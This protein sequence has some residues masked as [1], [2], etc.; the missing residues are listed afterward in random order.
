MLSLSQARWPSAAQLSQ[1]CALM[2]ACWLPDWADLATRCLPMRRA[3]APSTASGKTQLLSCKRSEFSGRGWIAPLSGC[4]RSSSCRCE[5]D[6]RVES[7][8]LADI[9]EFQANHGASRVEYKNASCLV[10]MS[11]RRN[12]RQV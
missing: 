11:R 3:L 6:H 5:L 9:V 8:E 12:C 10:W 4:C 7:Q 1:A 2:A